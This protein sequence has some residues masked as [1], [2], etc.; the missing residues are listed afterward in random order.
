M[1]MYV[2][3]IVIV[4][5]SNVLYHICQKSTPNNANPFTALFTTY[6]TA[7]ILTFAA[8]HFYKTEAGFFQSF[9]GLNWTSIVLAISI[10]G[11]ELGYM[12]VY[13]AGWNISVGSLVANI[14]LALILIPIGVMFFKEDFGLN[15]ILG[16]ILCI[17]GLFLINR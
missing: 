17:I 1:F 9:K 16:S 11:L 15:K 6:V 8:S 3:S 4:V 13:R 14:I 2:F 5:A 10:V 7:A 12:L